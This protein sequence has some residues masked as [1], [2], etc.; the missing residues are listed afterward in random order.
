MFDSAAKLG[1]A[2]AIPLVGILMLHVG[3]RWSFAA[4][5]LLSLGYFLVFYKT[6]REPADQI[7]ATPS[8]QGGESLGFL[9]RQR[10]VIG[11]V[12]GFFGYNYCFNFLVLWL[13]TYFGSLKLDAMHSILFSTIPWLVATATD[14]LVGGLWVDQMIR[15]GHDE[16]RVR[17]GVL[18]GGTVVGLAIAGAMFTTNSVFA[19]LWISISLGGLCAAAPVGWSIPSIISPRNSVGKVGGIL[20]TGNQISGI[21]APIITGY[22]VAFTHSFLYAFGVAALML[23]TGIACYVFLLG[24]IEPFTTVEKLG[25]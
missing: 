11:L 6:Y 9:L 15:R 8:W 3:W 17:S 10:K 19:L 2:I 5:G 7:L 20:N 14:L 22:V 18:I 21:V 25:Q 12:T 4:S 16:T 1:P 24:R 23:V 13:P